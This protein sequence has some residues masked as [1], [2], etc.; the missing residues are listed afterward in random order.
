MMNKSPRDFFKVISYLEI[1]ILVMGTIFVFSEAVKG[2][3][4][5]YLIDANGH[6]IDLSNLCRSTTKPDFPAPEATKPPSDDSDTQK[7]TTAETQ[8]TT[9]NT[10]NQ[11]TSDE[12]SSDERKIPILGE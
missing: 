2:E 8:D 9:E 5:C 3:P 10:A 1:S 12:Q 6:S 11:K 7:A 4:L